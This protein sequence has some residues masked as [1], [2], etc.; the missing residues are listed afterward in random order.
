LDYFRPLG[1]VC[2]AFFNPCDWVLDLASVDLRDP[3]AEAESRARVAA[4]SLAFKQSATCAQQVALVSAADSSEPA[5]GTAASPDVAAAADAEPASSVATFAQAFPVLLSRSATHFSRSPI[6]IS[7]R[8]FQ[9]LSYALILAIY[10]APMRDDQRYIQNRLGL[11]QQYTGLL[12]IG[13][14]NCLA[15]FVSERNVFWRERADGVYETGSFFLT[16]LVLELPFELLGALLFSVCIGPLVGMGASPAQFFVRAFTVLCIV[17]S[18]E[19]FGILFCAFVRHAGF[20]VSLVNALLSAFSLMAGFM[21]FAMPATMRVINYVS[22]LRY[23]ARLNVVYEFRDAVVTCLPEQ[24]IAGGL[25]P[26]TSG[27]QVLQTYEFDAS[28]A[29]EMQNWIM[30]VVLTIGYRVL[31]FLALKYNRNRFAA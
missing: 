27:A 5:A 24:L 25:C 19:S 11:L 18:G 6:I 29:A 2:P 23:T 17:S 3:R 30:C 7:A 21:S 26:I 20:A 10:F 9:S 12:F 4:L 14:L 15:V 22:V 28:S 1:H 13:M 16:Y 8:I 31:A